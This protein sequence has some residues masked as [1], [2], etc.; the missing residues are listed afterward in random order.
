LVWRCTQPRLDD[1]DATSLRI[2]DAVLA[3]RNLTAHDVYPF[4][5]YTLRPHPDAFRAT[6]N[7]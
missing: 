3:T 2:S 1:Y 6:A 4:W 5:N 7:L